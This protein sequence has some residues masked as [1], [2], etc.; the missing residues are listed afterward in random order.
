MTSR[1]SFFLI[2]ARIRL[3]VSFLEMTITCHTISRVEKKRPTHQSIRSLWPLISSL[4]T[5]LQKFLEALFRLDLPRS[6]YVQLYVVSGIVAVIELI[7][8]AVICKQLY[9]RTLWLF[10]VQETSSFTNLVVPNSTASASILPALFYFFQC[11]WLR[12]SISLFLIK[13]LAFKLFHLLWRSLWSCL[14]RLRLLY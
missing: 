7:G 9:K 3:K 8:S 11:H 1:S 10:R 2:S 4:E 6:Y 14:S 12:A 13:S 5:G